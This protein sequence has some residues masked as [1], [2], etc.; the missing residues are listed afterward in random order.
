M[1]IS[2]N[3]VGKGSYTSLD[4]YGNIA[5]VEVCWP[6]KFSKTCD[7]RIIYM[8][9]SSDRKYSA[10]LNEQK[11]GVLIG[12]DGD[13]KHITITKKGNDYIY[14]FTSFN[15]R[16]QT[17]YNGFLKLEKCKC[18]KKDCDCGVLPGGQC[19]CQH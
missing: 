13:F 10:L 7:K 5:C 8:E 15:I 12:Q 6:F 3:Y 11:E 9:S 17:H 19:A 16:T 4:K 2:G 18:P 1:C 14:S